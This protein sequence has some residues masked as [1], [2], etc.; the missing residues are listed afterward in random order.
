MSGD[1][2]TKHEKDF[3]GNLTSY[4]HKCHSYSAE[5]IKPHV[6]QARCRTS[7]RNLK[8][9]EKDN[10][11]KRMTEHT[12]TCSLHWHTQTVGKMKYELK[13]TFIPAT[14]AA[15][16]GIIYFNNFKYIQA[17]CPLLRR[18]FKLQ[19]IIYIN[20][21]L[22]IISGISLQVAGVDNKIYFWVLCWLYSALELFKNWEKIG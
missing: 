16:I 1:N 11:V 10:C 19:N 18:N 6:I 3:Y 22:V 17:R 12:Y 2:S 14:F 4:L 9:V 15:V 13:Q 21:L 20:I 7:K 8:Q 5:T